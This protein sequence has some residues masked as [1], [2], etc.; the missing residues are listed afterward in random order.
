MYGNHSITC[1]TL[2]SLPQAVSPALH[3]LA[4]FNTPLTWIQLPPYR[5]ISSC[6]LIVATGL[7]RSVAEVNTLCRCAAF[8]QMC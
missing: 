8:I 3:L 6:T 5:I 1:A 2:L 4:P 7:S